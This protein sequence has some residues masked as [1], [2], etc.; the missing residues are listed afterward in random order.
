MTAPSRTMRARTPPRHVPDNVNL[1]VETMTGIPS[2]PTHNVPA[3]KRA[4]AARELASAGSKRARKPSPSP[5]GLGTRA[6]DLPEGTRRKGADK[7][8]WVVHVT[9]GGSHRWKPLAKKGKPAPANDPP[10]VKAPAAK[11]AKAKP[12]EAAADPAKAKSAKPAAKAKQAAK[13]AAKPA[14]AKEPA[15][16]DVAAKA[17]KPARMSNKLKGHMTE[18]GNFVFE[19]RG[20]KIGTNPSRIMCG[21]LSKG[22]KKDLKQLKSF[23]DM[24]VDRAAVTLDPWNCGASFAVDRAEDTFRLYGGHDDVS[25]GTELRA[26]FPYANNMSVINAYMEAVRD[27]LQQKLAR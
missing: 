14:Q 19:Y 22:A 23:L 27:A 18:Y 16:D 21:P 6:A 8:F 2:Q 26:C 10:K 1:S 25:V 5:S 7:S 24:D 17:A 15:A 13:Q 4:P 12:A 3:G 20:I 11:P 9:A